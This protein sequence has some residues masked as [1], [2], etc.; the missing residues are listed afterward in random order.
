MGSGSPSRPRVLADRGK[1]APLGARPQAAP[2][3]RAGHG[4]V[5]RPSISC[6]ARHLLSRRWVDA[7]L[8][9]R[10][11]AFTF[12]WAAGG[13]QFV[14]VESQ[15]GG[16]TSDFWENCRRLLPASGMQQFGLVVEKIGDVA[17]KGRACIGG[18]ARRCRNPGSFSHRAGRLA[19]ERV[20]RAVF[21]TTRTKGRSTVRCR[22]TMG[23]PDCGGR[24]LAHVA[25]WGPSP[26]ACA[27]A[28]PSPS[29]SCR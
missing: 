1:G 8:L 11:Q 10:G 17:P 3:R 24:P 23:W 9:D 12:D 27:D 29:G 2:L 5:G 7:T 6:S 15:V 21:R 22:W 26:R 20:G 4:A 16:K 18:G 13:D 25:A 14:G 19:S 28:A